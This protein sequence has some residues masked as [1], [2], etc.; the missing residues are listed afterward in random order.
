MQP[1]VGRDAHSEAPGRQRW[2]KNTR[3]AAEACEHALHR[4]LFIGRNVAR[5]ERLGG[6]AGD[7]AKGAEEDQH[8]DHPAAG[9]E[10]VAD[11]GEGRKQKAG[12]EAALL[13][14]ALENRP[15]ELALHD[16]GG[17]ADERQRQTLLLRL[18][19]SGPC[20]HRD[21]LHAEAEH[22]EEIHSGEAEDAGEPPQ[23]DQRTG[24]IR[25]PPFERAPLVRRQRLGQ[26]KRAVEPVDHQA[27]RRG[28][29]RQPE[30]IVAQQPADRRPDHKAEAM[31]RPTCPELC[32]A[33][34]T[35]RRA[36]CGH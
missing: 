9:G 1:G 7:A 20:R 15:D 10:A 24:R 3:H 29:E 27:P 36:D 2:A 33:S 5:D 12:R 8:I 25:A 13:A 11:H 23:H 14:Q 32:A 18:Q 28:K 4:A 19:P 30:V 22:V 21:D 6:R 34:P 26:H 31:G 16:R 35:M 17:D